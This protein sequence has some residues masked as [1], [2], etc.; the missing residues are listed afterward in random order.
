MDQTLFFGGISTETS[1]FSNRPITYED[2]EPGL[3]RGDCCFFKA[4]GGPL[5]HAI[6]LLEFARQRNLKPVGG[7]LASA[8]VGAPV[9]QASYEALRDELLERMEAAS[10]KVVALSLHGAMMSTECDD[11]EGDILA[12]AR[13]IVGAQV[14]IVVVLDPHAHLTDAM[15]ESASL[16]AFMR[17][18]PHTDGLQRWNDALMFAGA[19]IDG[20]SP[21]ATA[22]VDIRMVGVFP[23]SRPP[24]RDLVDWI[25]EV[26]QRPDIVSVSLVHGFPWG[27]MPEMGAKALV[28][29]NSD[30]IAKSAACEIRDRLWAIREAMRPTFITIAAAMELAALDRQ[31][32]LVLADV[33]DNPGGGAPSDSNFILQALIEHGIGNIAVGLMIDPEA[34]RV[35]HKVGVGGKLAL[36]IG[37]K[38]SRFSGHPIDLDV[39][40]RALRQDAVMDI[41]LTSGFPMGDTA[42]VHAQG[43]DI[44]L[45]SLPLQ[46]YAPTGFTHLGIDPGARDVLVVKSSVHFEAFFTGI[47]GEIAHV[48]S[49]GAIDYDFSRLSLRRVSRPLWPRV[50]NPFE[51]HA[52]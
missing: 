1:S 2:F 27:D 29:A 26:A 38:V 17:E 42:W 39:E 33:A 14:P 16:L 11:C 19:M 5:P 22:V 7:I 30:S 36:R 46:M 18:Y 37:G 13:A 43:I 21:P 12:R 15:V 10:P 35:C 25:A 41:P 50:G 48:G 52:R 23:T 9:Q 6:P 34:V 40:V 47:A 32:P 8:P 4:E 31:G 49:P 51:G 45:A 24:M 20:M 28:Y 44:A 3:L